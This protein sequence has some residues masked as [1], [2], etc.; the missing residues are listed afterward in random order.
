MPAASLSLALTGQRAPGQAVGTG[1]RATPGPDDIDSEPG[2]AYFI[3]DSTGT[4]AGRD[5]PVLLVRKEEIVA[6][7]TIDPPLAA[8]SSIQADLGMIVARSAQRFGSKPALIAG[9][10]TLT[11]Q[12]LHELCDRVAGGLHTLG[13]RP[14]DRVSLYSP[15]RWEWVAAS[16]RSISTSVAPAMKVPCSTVCRRCTR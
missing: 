8:I 12:A 14:G 13:V 10:Q 5:R 11:Y 16:K 6:E 15:N 3:G 1:G 7:A 2:R 9:G 4:W